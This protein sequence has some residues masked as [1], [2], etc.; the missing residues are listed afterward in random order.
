MRD[1]YLLLFKSS[2]TGYISC[3]AQCESEKV[4]PLLQ[5]I[6]TTKTEDCDSRAPAPVRAHG[7]LQV[8]AQTAAPGPS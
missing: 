2:R 5:I 7:T 8:L 1:S 4:G 6:K 3:E